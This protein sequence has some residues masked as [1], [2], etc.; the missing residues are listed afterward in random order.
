MDCCSND[1]DFL[2]RQAFNVKQ[3]KRLSQLTDGSIKQCNDERVACE[4]ERSASVKLIGNMLHDTVPVSNDEVC[5]CFFVL[6]LV[7]YHNI[8]Q[9]V[10]SI[11]QKEE[12]KL[13][14]STSID[15]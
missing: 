15:L 6:R 4:Q 13:R 12:E 1:A 11:P 5:S 3:L 8:V 2:F 9:L 7:T 14:E 10:L